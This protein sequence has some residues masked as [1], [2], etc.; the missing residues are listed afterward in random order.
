MKPKNRQ[1]RPKARNA[2]IEKHIAK[3]LKKNGHLTFA[4][5]GELM[6]LN[7]FGETELYHRERTR[8]EAK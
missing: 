2:V 4:D 5:L 1:Y 7:Y 3:W 8:L 6:A